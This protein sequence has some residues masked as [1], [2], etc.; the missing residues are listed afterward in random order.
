MNF[1]LRDRHVIRPSDNYLRDPMHTLV[2]GGQANTHT[3]LL[4]HQLRGLQ[5]DI[6]LVSEYASSF[7]LPWKH[8]KV[9]VEWLHKKRLNQKDTSSFSSYASTMLSLVP[10]VFAFLMDC[11]HTSEHGAAHMQEHIR[12]YGL[13]AS[14][15]GL[16]QRVDTCASNV[17]YLEKLVDEYGELFIRL[18]DR[19]KVKFHH[20][21]HLHETIRRFNR[22]LS[23]FVTERRHRQVKKAAVHVFRH[24]E[25]TVL[26]AMV[27]RMCESFIGDASL[28]KHSFLVSP[29]VGQMHG[30]RIFT[31]TKAVL[32]CGLLNINDIVF[33][34]TAA[35][36]VG[37][38]EKFW[39]C[40][41]TIVV[42]IASFSKI[43]GDSRF[44]A[45]DAPITIFVASDSIVDAV[46]W[47]R[48]ENG[49]I[50]IIPPFVQA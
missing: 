31:S 34:N 45:D 4:L 46:P 41:N 25:N 10:I 20:M 39:E 40:N 18:Y 8:G 15:I 44:W 47:R 32:F 19:A 9:S 49:A 24:L 23:C 30:Q 21:Y 6:E 35:V 38:I 5:V 37:R 11:V 16:L 33:A 7:T 29:K 48:C 1:D 22:C 17:E 2:S 42:C 50:R 26:S 13:L 3:A 43:G 14:I 27:T 36:L 12:C 28:F